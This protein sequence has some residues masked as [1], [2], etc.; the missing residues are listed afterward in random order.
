MI[1]ERMRRLGRRRDGKLGINHELVEKVRLLVHV[2]MSE[3][4]TQRPL[5]WYT[6]L[7]ELTSS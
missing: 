3:K 6:L 2:G 1:Q 5:V 7:R 4:G